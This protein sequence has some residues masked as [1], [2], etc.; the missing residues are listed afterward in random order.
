MEKLS[1]R[2]SVADMIIDVD[3]VRVAGGGAWAIETIHYGLVPRANRGSWRSTS[4]RS[5]RAHQVALLNVMEA[6]R[7]DPRL[8]LRLPL[9]VLVVASANGGLHEPGPDHHPLKDRFGA[10]SAH[11][12]LDLADEIEVVRQEADLTAEVPGR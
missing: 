12:P 11:Y 8:C 10:E 2:T 6:G 9:D 3:P 5:R 7:P 1:T 4:C